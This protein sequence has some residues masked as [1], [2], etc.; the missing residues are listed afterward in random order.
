LVLWVAAIASATVDNIPFTI[1]L[2]P[3]I[4]QLGH[5]GIPTSPLWWALALGAGFGGNATP[6]GSTANIIVV[7]LSEKTRTPITTRM[8]VRAGVPVMIL[9]CTLGSV[10]FALFFGWI[11]LL[12]IEFVVLPGFG[13]AGMLGIAC[14]L[15]GLFGMLIRNAPDE[16]PWPETPMDWRIFNSGVLGLAFG[17][18]GFAFFAWLLSRFLPKLQ[19]L[20]G[21]V[22][23]PT[24]GASAAGQS[25]V[26]M[27]APNAD[28]AAGLQVG[29]KGEVTSRLR[30]AGRA[31]F[32]D[33]IVDVVAA[34]EFLAVGTAVE[35]AE[36]HGNRVV[37]RPVSD[38]EA[39]TG[40]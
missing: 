9:T 23:V 32:G 21:L 37:V 17:F 29:E 14:L 34:G 38:Q 40:Q 30:P 16:L 18:V 31:R 1:A 36:I 8:W 2:V 35:I 13:I 12:L 24:T 25:R 20:S 22:L 10:L 5:L 15:G 3:V 11:V 4:Q 7:T 33:A 28:E 39:G 26:S 27:T 6:I 19:F